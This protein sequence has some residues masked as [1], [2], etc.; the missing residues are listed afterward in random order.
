[1]RPL[2]RLLLSCLLL[3]A[4]PLQGLAAGARLHCGSAHGPEAAHAGMHAS[5]E[6]HHHHDG[7]A[8]HEHTG[9]DS[10]AG[11]D[12]SSAGPDS[13]SAC[14]LC[15]HALALPVAAW[16]LDATTPPRAVAQAPAAPPPQ[17]LTDRLER[18]PR[19]RAC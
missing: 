18:P 9:H 17:F 13:C 6:A 1:M 3:L 15:C 16:P 8:A 19:T 10:P 2:L 14:A 7:A 12:A 11:H 4:L 5:H